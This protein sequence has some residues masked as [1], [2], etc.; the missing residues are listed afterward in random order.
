MTNRDTRRIDPE[1]D[2]FASRFGNAQAISWRNRRFG[3]LVDPFFD[4][5]LA[6][7]KAKQRLNENFRRMPQ[8][9]VLLVGIEVPGRE[10]DIK[11]VVNALTRS[12]HHVTQ[13]IV[14]M[15]SRGKFDNVNYAISQIDLFRYD[16]IV[17]ADD[18]IAVPSG[19][20][21]H[22]LYLAAELD[23]KMFQPAH[24]FHSCSTY[25]VNQRHWN[26]L[27]RETN[28]VECGP[29][30]GFHHSTFDS[31]LPFP[32]LRWAWGID[33]YWSE[34][35]RRRG[36]KIGVLDAVPIRHKRPIGRSYGRIAAIEEARA[37]LSERHVNH[38]RRRFLTTVRSIYEI[39]LPV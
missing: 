19:F 1:Q 17:V 27:A 4:L 21:D 34:L 39:E 38:C 25:Q 8:A 15:E 36:W 14:P 30:F 31:L 26:T 29:V 24:R 32:N 16:W 35:A 23:F 13:L 6:L 3:F 33:V 2:F 7:S 5:R 18:D 9:R 12:R 20:L 11:E 22:T 10:Q 28:F 37:F